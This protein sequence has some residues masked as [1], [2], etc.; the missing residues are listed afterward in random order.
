MDKE[1]ARVERQCSACET[2]LAS[3]EE[4]L[5][6]SEERE[7]KSNAALR[8]TVR[9]L[10]LLPLTD[11]EVINRAKTEAITAARELL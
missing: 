5:N 3:T 1:I 4:R 7:R 8:A 10:D 9:V 6:A 2:K 11:S